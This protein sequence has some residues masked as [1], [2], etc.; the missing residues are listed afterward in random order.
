MTARTLYSPLHE[1]VIAHWTMH[2]A[3]HTVREQ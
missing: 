3:I 1:M 2:D